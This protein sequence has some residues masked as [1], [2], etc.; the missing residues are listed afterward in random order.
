LRYDIMTAVPEHW[1][2]LIPEHIPGGNNRRIQLRRMLMQRLLA[3]D[4]APTFE[5]VHPRTTLLRQEAQ[6]PPSRTASRENR[7]RA[8]ARVFSTRSADA[9]DRA[10]RPQLAGRAEAV[11]RGE[12]HSGLAFAQ[13]VPTVALNTMRPMGKRPDNVHSHGSG[14]SSAIGRSATRH[15][16]IYI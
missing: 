16:S 4:P 8:L 6:C 13:I 3:S 9:L 12:G 1:I 11:G 7:S 15:R 10:P 2:P 14:P 5:R